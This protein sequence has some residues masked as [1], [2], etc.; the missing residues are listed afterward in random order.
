[1]LPLH[2]PARTRGVHGVGDGAVVGFFVMP[3][4]RE[5]VGDP[6]VRWFDEGVVYWVVEALHKYSAG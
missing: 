2:N 4:G 6:G 1:M 5:G 3:V